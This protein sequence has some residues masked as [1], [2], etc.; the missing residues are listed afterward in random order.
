VALGGE[1]GV[2]FLTHLSMPASAGTVL[3]LVKALPVTAPDAPR[4]IGVDDW[5]L[6]KGSTYGTIVVDLDRRRV[7]DL[8]PPHLEQR[9]TRAARTRWRFGARCASAGLP[10]RAG[11]CTAS[12]PNGARCRSK[13]EDR[14]GR[15]RPS[16]L[17]DEVQVRRVGWQIRQA[18]ACCLDRFLHAFHFVDRKPVHQNRLPLAPA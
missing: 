14:P 9:L 3:R 11:R 13:P 7:V 17:L 2:R 6:R 18:R 1:G 15:W 16:S 4:R 5:A 8:L 10:A 12:W